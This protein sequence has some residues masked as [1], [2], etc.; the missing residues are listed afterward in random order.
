MP[1]AS[2]PMLGT[3]AAHR[4]PTPLRRVGAVGAD[5]LALGAIV[6][7]IP[8]VILGIGIPIALV[9]QLLLSIGRLF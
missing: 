5:V 6:L 3:A 4:V 2:V 1:G 9:A 7:S 8:F